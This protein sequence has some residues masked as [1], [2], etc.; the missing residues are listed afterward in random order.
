M[1]IIDGL[2]I[3]AGLGLI[4]FLLWFFFGPKQGKAAVLQGG[5]QE[6]T[7]RV[8]G[9]YQPNIVT[10]KAGVPVRLKFDRREATDCSNRVV[11]PDFSISRALPAFA[12]TTIQFTPEQPGEYPFACAMNMYR[13]TIVV[14]PDGRTPSADVAVP[15]QVPPSVAPKPS[16]EERPAQAEFMI[17]DMRTITTITA[18]EDV[19]ER[20]PGV[21]RVQVNAATERATIDYIPG[22]VAPERLQQAIKQAGFEAKSITDDEEE[23]DRGAISRDAEVADVTRRFVV[24]LVLT[25]PVLIGAMWHMLL[26]MPDGAWGAFIALLAN[27]YVQL[28]LTTPVLFYSGWGFFKGTWYTLK[29][30]TADMNTLIGIGTGAAYL[31]SLVA[32]FF[33]SWLARQEVAAAVYYETA[34]VIVT[35]ILLG[36]LLEVRAKAGTSAAIETLLALQARTAR[37]RRAGREEDIPVEEVR[38]GELV[39]VRPGEK[40]PVD[41]VIREG[42]STIDES[43]VTGESVP[44]TKGPGDPVIGAT[45]NTAGGF[46]FEAT[47][48]GKDTMLAQIVRL[49]QEAQGSKAPIQRLA[50]VV[51]SYFVPAVIMIA[52]LTFVTWFVFGPQPAFLLALLNTVAVL[53]IA[54]PCALGLATPTSIMVATGKGAEHGILIKNAEALEVTGKLTTVVL[55]KTGTLTQGKHAVQDIVAAEGVRESELL[56]LAA[57]VERGSEHPLAHAIVQAAEERG[58]EIPRAHDFRSYTGKGAEARVDGRA[59]IVGSRRLM[60]ERQLHGSIL[61]EHAERLTDQGKTVIYVAANNGLLGLVSLADIVRPTSAAAIA[62]LHDLGIEV[63]MITGDNWG[64]GRAIAEK[65]GID[66]VRAEVLPEHKATEVANLQR[67]QKII[68]MVGDG[69]NDAPALAQADVGLAIGAGTDV[70]IESADVVLIKNDVFD[71]ARTVQLSRATMRNIKQNLFLRSSTTGSVFRSPLACSI[72]SLACCS[73]RLL[74]LERWPR[75]PFRW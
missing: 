9:A 56:R 41:G 13:G 14:A 73:H 19:L 4:A 54:C 57:A 6:A 35:L 45:V 72:R 36:R 31:Y 32:T 11:L 42:E 74:R 28:V 30:R 46:V 3:A 25:I 44:V 66:T 33:A 16:A 18:I 47:K 8:E 50:D 69:I 70:A 23:T 2:V 52:V 10:V 59:I 60:E 26:P 22:I 64:V 61:T 21:E 17:C 67:Q 51:S 34:A 43:M 7:I 39:V 63:A 53:L 1:T 40:I 68:A 38:A 12:T 27:P 62:A 49:V 75:V 58:L 71:V 5:V 48:V 55:D 24:A 37:V 65:L 20:L 29:N 15:A